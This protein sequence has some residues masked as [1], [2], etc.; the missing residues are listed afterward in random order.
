MTLLAA[1]EAAL[2]VTRADLPTLLRQADVVTLHVP[3]TAET[4]HLI[5]AKA[6]AAMKPGAILINTSRGPL[7]DEAALVAALDSG[8]LGGAG[9]DVFEQEPL[10]RGHPLG[11]ALTMSSLR[12]I[13]PRE[14]AMHLRRR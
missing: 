10:P 14:R 4:R 9:L 12:R 5:D 6:L 11:R 7:V 1:T 3:A 8:R 13:S 2:G